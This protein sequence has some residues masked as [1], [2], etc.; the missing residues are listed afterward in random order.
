MF[1][2]RVWEKKRESEEAYVEHLASLSLTDTLQRKKHDPLPEV[3]PSPRDRKLNRNRSL[4]ERHYESPTLIAQ[5]IHSR[6]SSV[7]SKPQ[8]FQVSL[9]DDDG[10]SP[11][12]VVKRT[13]FPASLDANQPQFTSTPNATSLEDINP[14][15]MAKRTS[16]PASLDANQPQFTNT[17]NATSSEDI[18]PYAMAK[19]TSFPA[20]LDA[21]QPQFTST[22]NATSSEEVNPYASSTPL[23]AE[24]RVLPVSVLC[25]RVLTYRGISWR[26]KP[27]ER[28]KAA[29]ILVA[30]T[31]ACVVYLN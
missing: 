1:F 12:A 7:A 22:P 24:V 8:P 19:R 6:S 17:P 30:R 9:V 10:L 23:R 29:S 15:A 3:P 20:S 25:H 21:N 2:N 28:R 16:F 14:Y 13:S 26:K 27:I 4:S 31:C 5:E 11:Y 18:N